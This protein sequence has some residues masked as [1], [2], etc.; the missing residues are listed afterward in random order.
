MALQKRKGGCYMKT[1]D[2]AIPT[3]KVPRTILCIIMLLISAAML[4]AI[5]ISHQEQPTPDGVIEITCSFQSYEIKRHTRSISYDLLLTSHDYER[6]F[7]FSFFDGYKKRISPEELCMGTTYSLCV[8]PYESSYEIYRLSSSDNDLLLTKE[9]AYSNSQQTA[10]VLLIIFLTLNICFF[11]LLLTALH[12]PHLFSERI[13]R[14]LFKQRK[15][16]SI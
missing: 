9:E 14:F 6:P 8:L 13:K 3:N 12:F 15:T 4:S 5:F 16:L 11:L 1:K 2:Y 10:S 7:E